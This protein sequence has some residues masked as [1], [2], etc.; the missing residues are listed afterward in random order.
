ML[1]QLKKTSPVGEISDPENRARIAALAY[2][3][4]QARGCPLGTPDEDW[5]RAERE[6]SGLND[7]ESRESAKAAVDDEEA[8]SRALR[9]PI[10]SEISRTFYGTSK[11]A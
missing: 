4:W 7:L 10:R 2:E 5:F 9:F 8:D 3:F 6:I 11:R 1:P